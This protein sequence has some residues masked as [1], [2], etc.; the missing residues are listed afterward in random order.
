MDTQKYKIKL[1]KEKNLVQ[2]EL[3]NISSYNK[4][5][6]KWRPMPEGKIKPESD[7]NNLADRFEDFGERVGSFEKL[8]ARLAEI[9]KALQAIEE[10]TYGKCDKCGVDIK[11]DRLEANPAAHTCKNCMNK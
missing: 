7:N 6:K 1:E 4:E 2:N 5:T 9:K 8:D 11:E 10:G 3:S